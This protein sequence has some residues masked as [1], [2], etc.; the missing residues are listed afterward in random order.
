LKLST[1]S[2][3]EDLIFKMAAKS[4]KQVDGVFAKRP[5]PGSLFAKRP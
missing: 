4:N 1:I 5:Q 3:D 2:E